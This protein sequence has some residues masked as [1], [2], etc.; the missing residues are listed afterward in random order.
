MQSL[1]A[2]AGT[3]RR[4]A[5]WKVAFVAFVFVDLL[6]T[7]YAFSHGFAELNPLV[8]ALLERPWGLALAKGLAPLIIAWL[9]PGRLLVPSIL[10]LIGINGWNLAQLVWASVP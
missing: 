6:L 4:E 7:L 8:L 3:Y 2:S 10:L 9:V 5:A 1:F